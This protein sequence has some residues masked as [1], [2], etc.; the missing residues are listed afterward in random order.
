MSKQ[1]D[2]T[3]EICLRERALKE[4]TSTPYEPAIEANV[5]KAELTVAKENW[6]RKKGEA[7]KECVNIHKRSRT[8]KYGGPNVLR[9]NESQA[10]L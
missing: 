3:M 6:L 4:A 10:K 8:R 2:N 1:Y 5:T 7:R 9:R